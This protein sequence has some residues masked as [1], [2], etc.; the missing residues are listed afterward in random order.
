MS[1]KQ[2]VDKEIADLE[3]DSPWTLAET[4]HRRNQ[5][6]DV[7]KWIKEEAKPKEK[8]WKYT[9]EDMIL[10]QDMFV[11]IKKK[12]RHTT[13]PTDKFRQWADDIRKTREK[14][15]VN[16][17]TIWRVFKWAH[18]DCFWSGNIRSPA[19]LYKQFE[20]LMARMQQGNGNGTN[21]HIK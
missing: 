21:P 11:T 20:T 4:T 13:K 10:V 2:R 14:Y 18:E 16:G 7:L 6:K 5:L 8:N 15:K 3:E 9:A 19:K 1:I 17:T 12:Y